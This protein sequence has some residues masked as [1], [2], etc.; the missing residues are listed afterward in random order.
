VI[1]TEKIDDAADENGIET[2]GVDIDVPPRKFR[3]IPPEP[4]SVPECPCQ[5]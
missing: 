3:C 4:C 5:Q 1:R 2:D